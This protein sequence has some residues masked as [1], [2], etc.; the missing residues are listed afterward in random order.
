MRLTKNRDTRIAR[1]WTKNGIT[2]MTDKYIPSEPLIAHQFSEPINLSNHHRFLAISIQTWNRHCAATLN[3]RWTEWS[4][5]YAWST[6]HADNSPLFKCKRVPQFSP[7]RSPKPISVLYSTE[8]HLSPAHVDRSRLTW[9]NSRQM[10][11]PRQRSVC[12]ALLLRK[13]IITW[14]YSVDVSHRRAC[15]LF[16]WGWD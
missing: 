2:D 6:L 15:C 8:R 10:N 14:R 4:Q 11:T 1:F 12:G 16:S 7:Y 9:R 3:P 5:L 13:I